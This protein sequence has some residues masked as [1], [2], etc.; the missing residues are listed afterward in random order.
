M[1]VDLAEKI[2]WPVCV[3]IFALAFIVI[4]SRQI[5]DAFKRIKHA[6]SKN[7]E[8]TFHPN[9]KSEIDLDH[10]EAESSVSQK[11]ASSEASSKIPP[12]KNGSLFWLSHDLMWLKSVLTRGGSSEQILW[13]FSQC[14]H[15]IQSL[16]LRNDEVEFELG[17]YLKLAHQYSNTCW[18][19]DKRSDAAVRITKMITRIGSFAESSQPD[20]ISYPLET[21]IKKFSHLDN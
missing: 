20:Y 7:L 16:E 13:G 6:R 5:K 19:K 9:C 17:N 15:H 8:A 4:F 11:K 10:C 3:L 12:G 18:T 14:M 2:I 21:T 1:L